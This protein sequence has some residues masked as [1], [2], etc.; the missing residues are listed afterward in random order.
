MGA[1]FLHWLTGAQGSRKQCPWATGLW[2]VL[3]MTFSQRGLLCTNCLDPFL[4]SILCRV[5]AGGI[6]QAG[7]SW[8][9]QWGWLGSE[10]EPATEEGPQQ[11]PKILS[12]HGVWKTVSSPFPLRPGTISVPPCEHQSRND[13]EG[14]LTSRQKKQHSKGVV[15][16][17]RECRDERDIMIVG[18]LVRDCLAVYGLLTHTNKKPV[19]TSSHGTHQAVN[20]VLSLLFFEAEFFIKPRAPR[21]SYTGWPTS[22]GESSFSTSSALGLQACVTPGVFIW[23]MG[24]WA[25]A[26]ILKP[27]A[28]Y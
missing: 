5:S 8:W 3:T 16:M 20:Y 13:A 25:Q 19:L 23:V 2:R 26:L 17:L 21:F 27:Q 11:L 1:V 6:T 12:G 4:P 18:L 22:L 9:Q 24:N 28:V 14:H 10:K 7:R 15:S